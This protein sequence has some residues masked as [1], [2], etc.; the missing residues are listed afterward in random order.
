MR[1]LEGIQQT[2]HRLTHQH[3]LLH[4]RN[5]KYID[6]SPAWAHTSA[7]TGR[8]TSG[9]APTHTPAILQHGHIQVRLL[10]NFVPTTNQHHYQP[11]W[12]TLYSPGSGSSRPK[13][14]RIRIH[15]TVDNKDKITYQ[16]KI[17][18]YE[19]SHNVQ[20]RRLKTSTWSYL[21]ED[22]R[23]RLESGARVGH[24]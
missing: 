19:H 1:Q 24:R 16:R 5:A 12:A 7:P 11:L 22:R 15:N 21:H 10:D 18:Q 6:N 13:S 2:E 17:L 9:S 8:D 4:R 14:M 3:Q 23:R 20:R